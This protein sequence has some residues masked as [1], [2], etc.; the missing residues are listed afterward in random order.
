MFRRAYGLADG[1]PFDTVVLPRCTSAA[2]VPLYPDVTRLFG[3]WSVGRTS[4]MYVGARTMPLVPRGMSVDF[5]EL[6]EFSRSDETDEISA[7]DVK[8]GCS[9]LG[10]V[11]SRS[12]SPVE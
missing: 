1:D 11:C 5:L 3:F 4:L 8:V 2:P 7:A 9:F 12:L 6:C 10:K